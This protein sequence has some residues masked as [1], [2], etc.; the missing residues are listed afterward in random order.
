[1]FAL[2]YGRPVND[3]RER[4]TMPQL[5]RYRLTRLGVAYPDDSH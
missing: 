4:L 3:V 2:D 5:F 1:V